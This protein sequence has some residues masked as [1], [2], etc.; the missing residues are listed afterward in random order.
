VPKLI[1]TYEGNSIH[2]ILFSSLT[3]FTEKFI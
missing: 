2:F 1:L 3:M